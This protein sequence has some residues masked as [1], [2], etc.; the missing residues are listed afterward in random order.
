MLVLWVLGKKASQSM[1]DV[2]TEYRKQ[3]GALGDSAISII[4]V[5][6]Q[7]VRDSDQRIWAL[8]RLQVG[9]RKGIDEQAAEMLLTGNSTGK[10]RRIGP[11]TPEEEARLAISKGYKRRIA[12]D[13]GNETEA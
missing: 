7:H 10:R 6:E 9:K 3:L 11:R 13:A 4:E 5:Q 2:C 8:M 1:A 12:S